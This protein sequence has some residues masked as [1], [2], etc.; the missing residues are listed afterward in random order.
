MQNVIAY[1]EKKIFFIGHTSIF[2]CILEELM[3]L[4][5]D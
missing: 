3:N 1:C 2:H 5:Y 4:M